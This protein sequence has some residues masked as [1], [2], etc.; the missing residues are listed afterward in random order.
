[1]NFTTLNSKNF[2]YGRIKNIV[3]DDI[4]ISMLKHEIRDFWKAPSA[5]ILINELQDLYILYIKP[6]FVKNLEK[7][8]QRE[9]YEYLIKNNKGLVAGYILFYKTTYNPNKIYKRQNIRFC[10][11][12][13]P[14]LGILRQMIEVYSKRYDMSF[15]FPYEPLVTAVKYWERY[16]FEVYDIENKEQLIDF[17][18]RNN[19]NIFIDSYFL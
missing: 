16:F 8:I 5:N 18:E 12:I 11:T 4:E 15:I 6:S 2:K 3:K 13:I 1:M 14:K 10:D 17:K 9:K 19:L 7:Y